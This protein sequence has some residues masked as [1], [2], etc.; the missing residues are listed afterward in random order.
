MLAQ[1]QQQQQQQQEHQ[2]ERQQGHQ[3]EQEQEQQQ[4]QQQTNVLTKSDC[5]K[6]GLYILECCMNDT[7]VP[8]VFPVHLSDLS[9]TEEVIN[10]IIYIMEEADV[11]LLTI[12]NFAELQQ[13]SDNSARMI[14]EHYHTLHQRI[15]HLGDGLRAVMNTSLDRINQLSQ[16]P[17]ASIT[18]GI[19]FALE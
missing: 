13:L 14:E 17:P 10:D 3:Q 4:Q 2:E 6:F 15:I 11:D 16:T 5:G 18:S 19:Y 8:P 1:Q 12:F 9:N 7:K